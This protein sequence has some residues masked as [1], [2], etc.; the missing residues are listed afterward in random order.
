MAHQLIRTTASVLSV[1]IQD[2]GQVSFFQHL[3]SVWQKGGRDEAPFVHPETGCHYRI[4]CSKVA[5]GILTIAY[6]VTAEHAMQLEKE[7][8]EE[9][10]DSILAASVNGVVAME[11]ERDSD[12]TILDFRIT[13]VNQQVVKMVGRDEAALIGK[14]YRSVFPRAVTNG[15]FQLKCDV[16]ERGE[17][18]SREIF[19]EGDDLNRWFRLTISR[20]GKNGIV[21]TLIDMTDS[22]DDKLEVE[23]LAER[24]QTVIGTSQSGVHTFKPV[25]DE[26]GEITD[27]RMMMVNQT[28]GAYIGQT[29]ET[30][31]G[32][33]AST[34]FPAY[35]TNGI[36]EVYKD[37]YLHGTR[38]HFDFHYEDGYDVFFNLLV[39]KLDDEV[40]VTLTD[41]TALKRMQRELEASIAELK[42][43]NASLEQ[44]AHAASHDLQEP[45]RKISFYT[46][47]LLAEYGDT[48]D[49]T[50][51]GY[52]ERIGTAG[53]RMHRLVK[54][55]L[56][57]AEVGANKNAWEKV[58][59]NVLMQE[60]LNV[61]E[62]AIAERDAKVHL[63][64]LDVVEGDSLHLHQL[65]QNLVSNSL[66]YSRHHVPPE[67]HIRSSRMIGHETGLELNEQEK[68]QLYCV[69]EVK[70]NGLGFSAEDAKQ[71]FKIF[72]RLP[73]H[74]NQHSGTG[75]G[76]A[77]VQRVVENHKGFI[78]AEGIP[79]E[80]AA[81]RVF[82][83]VV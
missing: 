4:C 60:V 19:Y 56:V 48:L 67:I 13:R 23:R 83:P 10:V 5:A 50:G 79:G 53:K 81:F 24:L 31:T 22:K 42:R 21:E 7:Q 41:H 36:F 16:I 82:L 52:L 71:I 30:L 46:D 72:Q 11:A 62:I 40:L 69:V 59:L 75:I 76:L 18:V 25:F 68:Q 55:L 26:N 15:L 65:F 74:R 64:T 43:S 28:I 37:C 2:V 29:V 73:Q 32:A 9:L 54:D 34:Y 14:S 27:F 57:F 8:Q 70:D 3:F 33:L 61:L 78:T 58:N 35:K 63:E 51:Y 38:H 47:K 49:D 20:L 39:V 1:A 6:D 17:S 44:F 45:L 77:I 80:G 12:G 66:K